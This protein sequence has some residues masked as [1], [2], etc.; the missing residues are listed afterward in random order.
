MESEETTS[1]LPG[2]LSPKPG[3]SGC[4]SLSVARD[5]ARSRMDYGAVSDSNVRMPRHQAETHAS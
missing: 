3:C 2:E 1:A 4:L 5:N